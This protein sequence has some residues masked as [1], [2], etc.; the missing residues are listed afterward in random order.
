[1][2]G[3]TGRTQDAESTRAPVSTTHNRQTPT[4]VWLCKWQSV[5][6]AMPFMRAASKTLVPFGTRTDFPSIAR[7]T[8]PG[9]AVVVVIL[10][11]YSHARDFAGARRSA[12]ANPARTLPFQNM[13]IDFRTKMLQHRLNRRGGNLAEAADR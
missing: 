2:P 4:G 7:S 1:M 5:G 3:S 9:G 13:C 6:M 11:P 10:W 12:E 8:I